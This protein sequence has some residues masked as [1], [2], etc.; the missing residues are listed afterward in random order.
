MYYFL[1]L[2]SALCFAYVFLSYLFS[3]FFN[4]SFPQLGSNAPIRFLTITFLLFIIVMVSYMIPDHELGNRFMHAIGGGFLS[5]FICF[6]VVRDTKIHMS[7]MQFFVF[8]FLI[9]TSLGVA[10]EIAE[11]ILQNYTDYFIFAANIND[12]WLDLVSNTI[13]ALLGGVVF[14]SLLHKRPTFLV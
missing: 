1:I 2:V 10:N 11:F 14:T 9:V 12:T 4:N 6:L 7:K 8:S 13:G 5:F 3:L